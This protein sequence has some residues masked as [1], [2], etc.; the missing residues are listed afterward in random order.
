MLRFLQL[1]VACLLVAAIVCIVI[2]PFIDLPGTV[3]RGHNAGA[4]GAVHVALALPAWG[5]TITSFEKVNGFHTWYHRGLLS[6][7]L[8][9]RTS[10]L[11]C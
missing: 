11:L 8:A 4:N 2:S 7:D 5:F 10:A 3:L 9:N 6:R 1:A